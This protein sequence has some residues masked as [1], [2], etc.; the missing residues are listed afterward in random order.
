MDK[1]VK[2]IMA[3]T[4]DR[5]SSVR[6]SLLTHSAIINGLKKMTEINYRHNLIYISNE[7]LQAEFDMYGFKRKIKYPFKMSAKAGIQFFSGFRVAFHLPGMTILLPKMSNSASP[8]A[9]PGVYLDAN[10]RIRRIS[11]SSGLS[12]PSKILGS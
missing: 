10:Y 4:S 1:Y 3:I 12:P 8:P 2:L 11:V 7:S 5:V 9:E 6:Q